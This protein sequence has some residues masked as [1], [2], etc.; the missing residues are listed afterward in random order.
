M[1]QLEHQSI[2]SFSLLLLTADLLALLSLLESKFETL[3]SLTTG[4]KSVL[5]LWNENTWRDRKTLKF[6]LESMKNF[7]D[8]LS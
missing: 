6:V 8:K 7:F 5:Q 4:N 3:F 1:Q 2:P